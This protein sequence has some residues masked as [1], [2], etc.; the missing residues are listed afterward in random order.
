MNWLAVGMAGFLCVAALSSKAQQRLE[1][2]NL[3]FA[4]PVGF[5]MSKDSR[6][7]VTVAVLVPN[8]ESVK[9]WSEMVQVTILPFRAD[10]DPGA[11]MQAVEDE[12]L[13]ACKNG[14]PDPIVRRLVNGYL[15]A[16]MTFH[17]PSVPSI[18]KAE[19][20]VF[21]AIKANKAFYLVQRSVRSAGAQ[22]QMERIGKYMDEVSVCD[23]GLRQHPCP[24]LVPHRR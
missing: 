10:R 17:C 5:K 9:S 24:D 16:T 20:S 23:A 21:R 11:F 1:G 4:P 19:V 2:E 22:E 12:Q 7:G 14:V 3:L 6:E 15:A 13:A 18:G 8:S